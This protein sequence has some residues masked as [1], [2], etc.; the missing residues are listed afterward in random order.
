M[1]KLLKDIR[2]ARALK[3]EKVPVQQVGKKF[4]YNRELD[5]AGREY[6]EARWGIEKKAPR[7]SKFLAKRKM[8]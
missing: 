3:D 8:I 1:K 6:D 4:F 2:T 5:T 7:L